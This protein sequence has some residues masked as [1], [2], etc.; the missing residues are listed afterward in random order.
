[1]LRASC[2]RVFDIFECKAAFG[3]DT[4]ILTLLRLFMLGFHYFGGA[5]LL[6]NNRHKD[7]IVP[8]NHSYN[9][10]FAI[11]SSVFSKE[12]INLMMSLKDSVVMGRSN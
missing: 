4:C 11:K 12:K 7:S 10:M 3:V 2:S 9:L 1:M 8:L 5:L 6:G